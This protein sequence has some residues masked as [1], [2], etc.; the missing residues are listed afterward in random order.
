M[1]HNLNPNP[2]I[3]KKFKICR[4]PKR[5]V[6][7]RAGHRQSNWWHIV[8]KTESNLRHKPCMKTFLRSAVLCVLLVWVDNFKHAP[9]MKYVRVWKKTEHTFIGKSQRSPWERAGKIRGGANFHGILKYQRWYI[10]LTLTQGF[11]KSWKYAEIR[12]K[13]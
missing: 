11:R 10:S 6:A 12:N 2:R 7:R 1:I 9:C 13:T 8:W 5:N 4:N 3:S